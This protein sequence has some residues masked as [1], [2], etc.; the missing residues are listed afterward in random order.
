VQNQA[1]A[2]VGRLHE[3]HDMSD[4]SRIRRVYQRLFQ[5]DPS[6]TE[7]RLGQEFLGSGTDRWPQYVQALCGLSEFVVVD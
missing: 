6:P 1:D 4:E 2:L 3:G 7:L 5:R